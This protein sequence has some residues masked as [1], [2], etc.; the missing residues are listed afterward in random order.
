VVVFARNISFDFISKTQQHVLFLH[1]SIK[2]VLIF[3]LNILTNFVD[4]NYAYV[5]DYSNYRTFIDFMNKMEIYKPIEQQGL[6]FNANNICT[7]H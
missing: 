6:K 3:S 5:Q 1:M 2:F 4:F 7:L